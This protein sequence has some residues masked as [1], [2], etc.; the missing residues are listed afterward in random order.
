MPPP[1]CVCLCDCFFTST[2]TH[3]YVFYWVTTQYCGYLF[4]CS[5]C[6]SLAIGNPSSL[7]P[8][9]HEEWCL[10][11]KIGGLCVPTAVGLHLRTQTLELCDVCPRTRTH[12]CLRL[13]LSVCPHVSSGPLSA[14]LLFLL[15]MSFSNVSNLA[16]II[17][18][19][20]IYSAHLCTSFQ[21]R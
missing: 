9:F 12:F 19:V 2:R 20:V 11:A 7:A 18:H 21:N 5:N 10:E 1:P 16:D 3:R 6:S 14:F 15:A 4:R 17:Y 13:C 8:S